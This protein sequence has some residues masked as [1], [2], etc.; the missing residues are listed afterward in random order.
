[1]MKKLRKKGSA[2]FDFLVV[3]L[4]VV[5]IGI[6]IPTFTAAL[7]KSRQRTDLANARAL[8]SL[9]VAQYMNDSLDAG[10]YYLEEGG[11]TISEDEDGCIVIT[12]RNWGNRGEPVSVTISS[13]GYVTETV[14]DL[15]DSY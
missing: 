6:G 14:P 3:I 13:S 8:K 1:M 15:N 4:A 7:E 10:T 2:T 11:Q 12:S 5:G 9:V